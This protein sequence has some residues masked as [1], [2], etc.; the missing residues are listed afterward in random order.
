MTELFVIFNVFCV[1]YK[2]SA[3]SIG[4]EGALLSQSY[5]CPDG[6]ALEFAADGSLNKLYDPFNKVKTNGTFFLIVLI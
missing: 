4:Y 2:E 6:T 3:F 5:S 1:I